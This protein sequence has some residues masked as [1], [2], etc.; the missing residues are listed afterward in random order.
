MTN[1]VAAFDPV[2]FGLNTTL[3]V[4][5]LRSRPTC[6]RYCSARTA[7]V[8]AR[9]RD[10]RD[11]QRGAAGVRHRDQHRC[12]RD[13]DRF[14]AKWQRGRRHRVERR[15]TGS[16]EAHQAGS[17][18]QRDIQSTYR[19]RALHHGGLR[20]EHSECRTA[21]GARKTEPSLVALIV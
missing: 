15:S 10:A 4:Q 7:R 9:E 5:V 17:C 12:T 19:T 8:R 3:I 6:R 13:V 18:E 1:S 2:E 14:A 20:T 11:G 21:G 16:R